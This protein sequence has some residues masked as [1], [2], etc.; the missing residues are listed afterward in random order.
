MREFDRKF[1]PED[2]YDRR[3]REKREAEEK[4]KVEE[5]ERQAREAREQQR[6]ANISQERWD[7]IDERI[8]QSLQQYTELNFGEDSPHARDISAAFKTTIETLRRE[9]AEVREEL[10]TATSKLQERAARLPLV[11]SWKPD[12][13]HYLGDVVVCDGSVYQA[14][15]D[16]GRPVTSDDWICIARGGKDGRDAPMLNFRGMFDVDKKYAKFDVIEYAG[17]AFV[18]IRDNPAIIPGE[19]GWQ[20][21]ALPGGRGPE[22]AVGPPGKTGGRGPRGEATP[23]I[24]S[25][26][27]D[28][29]RY[30]AIPTLSD[31]KEGAPL[32][33]RGL[34]EQFLIE[35]GGVPA[36]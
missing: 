36:E 5:R 18:A 32:E 10:R 34:F 27:L 35:T 31:G 11:K 7:Q 9:I 1:G 30:T 20:V 13:V 19:D 21:L 17:G 8:R 22:G 23:T 33:L 29:K 14:K 24:I 16:T 26:V 12:T 15:R 6:A 2:Y 25:W 28:Y 3:L 4:R